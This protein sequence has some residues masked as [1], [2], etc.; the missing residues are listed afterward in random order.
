[1]SNESMKKV[2]ESLMAIKVSMHDV[3]ETG[4]N[5]KLDEAIKLLEQHNESGSCSSDAAEEVLVV[6]G[7]V[8]E[9]L[10]SIVTLLKLFSD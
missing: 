4:V 1:M 6:I 3:A 7:R 8:L 9:K 10:P 5:E 2:L